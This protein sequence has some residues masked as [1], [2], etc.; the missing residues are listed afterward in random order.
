[1]RYASLR[2]QIKLGPEERLCIQFAAEL[3]AA[4]LEGR[5]KGVFAHP[6]NELAYGHKTGIKGAISK[7]MGMIAGTPD[8]L[9]L[10][11]SASLAL[12]AKAPGGT[13][14]PNQR[15]F[16]EWCVLNLIPYEVFRTVEEGLSILKERGF[17]E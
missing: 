15:D 6:A 14:T 8:Y 16:E 17:L 4:V 11:R 10:Q 3:R 5:F 2:G 7:A 9:F 13:Q 12:E 1:M